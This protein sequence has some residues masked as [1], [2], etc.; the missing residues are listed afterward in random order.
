MTP[1]FHDF[2][3]QIIRHTCRKLWHEGSYYSIRFDDICHGIDAT[4]N[5]WPFE[6]VRVAPVFQTAK[7]HVRPER[8]GR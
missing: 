1:G 6:T 8:Q 2:P 7:I 5:Q 3:I 4:T